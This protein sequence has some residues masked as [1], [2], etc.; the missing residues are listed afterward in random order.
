MI[1]FNPD[2]GTVEGPEGKATLTPT[3]AKVFGLLVKRDLVTSEAMFAFLYDDNLDPPY[4]NAVRMHI[5]NIRNKLYGIGLGN[6][7]KTVWWRG[8]T[9]TEKVEFV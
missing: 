3:Q 5:H 4:M 2:F 9:L 6:L 1:K 7:I 8:W